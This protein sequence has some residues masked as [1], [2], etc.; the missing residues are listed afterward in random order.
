MTNEKTGFCIHCKKEFV[1][2]YGYR[3]ICEMC[4]DYFECRRGHSFC[5]RH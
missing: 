4:D 5:T 2:Q 3:N 1:P